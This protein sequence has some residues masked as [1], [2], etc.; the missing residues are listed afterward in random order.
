MSIHSEKME[1]FN[2]DCFPVDE[3]MS[4][5]L[6]MVVGEL[7][8]DEIYWTLYHMKYLRKWDHSKV[9]MFFGLN[10]NISALTGETALFSPETH[11]MQFR[12]DSDQPDL[13]PEEK[14]FYRTL[15]L[16]SELLTHDRY[17]FKSFKEILLTDDPQSSIN[18]NLETDPVVAHI[19]YYA[20]NEEGLYYSGSVSTNSTGLK[21]LF[22]PKTTNTT[23]TMPSTLKPKKVVS[24]GLLIAC[25]VL[26]AIVLILI[27]YAIVLYV[28]IKKRVPIESTTQTKPDLSFKSVKTVDSNH[29]NDISTT[30]RS[31]SIK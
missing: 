15:I 24:K 26:G 13:L 11:Q 20:F 9:R 1:F 12:W 21:L 14:F 28:R 4:P 30:L 10:P 29:P 8:E 22:S 18:C 27:I 5:C 7:D 25:I 17:D 19:A 31:Q 2:A 3:P 6:G 23:T 16:A